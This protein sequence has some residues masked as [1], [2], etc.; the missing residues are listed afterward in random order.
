MTE[1]LTQLRQVKDLLNKGWT[2]EVFARNELGEETRTD[3]INATCWCIGGAII[4]VVP[5]SLEQRS[6]IWRVV[7]K[8]ILLLGYTS[9]SITVFNDAPDTTIQQVMEVMDK[10]IALQES[11]T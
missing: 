9:Q 2:K 4:K 3:N 1:I 11:T 5:H 10:A 6:P 7:H 8:A